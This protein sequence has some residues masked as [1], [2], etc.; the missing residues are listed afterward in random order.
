MTLEEVVNAYVAAHLACLR[1]TEEMEAMA[2]AVRHAA[3][4]L[5]DWRKEAAPIRYNGF[6][7]A[8]F[9]TKAELLEAIRRWAAADQAVR[10]AWKKVPAEQK[11]ALK[12]PPAHG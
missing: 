9:P 1:A 10:D 5:K 11:Q 3:E 7:A 4:L 8:A 6:A 12:E 2:A